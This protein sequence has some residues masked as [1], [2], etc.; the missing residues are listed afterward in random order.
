M[1]S[2]FWSEKLRGKL[3]N[4]RRFHHSVIFLYSNPPLLVSCIVFMPSLIII[5]NVPNLII[6]VSSAVFTAYSYFQTCLFFRII[7]GAKKKLL[8]YLHIQ[9]FLFLYNS[10]FTYLVYFIG[11]TYFIWY[12]NIRS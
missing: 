8:L 4:L 9:L 3:S 6:T 2:V 7:D 1:G 10:I 12:Y 5:L 11:P